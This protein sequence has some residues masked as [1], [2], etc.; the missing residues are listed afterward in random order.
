MLVHFYVKLFKIMRSETVHYGNPEVAAGW[1]TSYACATWPVVSSCMSWPH[2]HG[3]EKS[4]RFSCSILR[5]G[6][7]SRKKCAEGNP[8]LE[9]AL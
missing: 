1:E 4:R 8:S 2:T 3:V 6:S 5:S 7:E 9:A